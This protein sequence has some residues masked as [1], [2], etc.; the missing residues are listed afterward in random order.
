MK[1]RDSYSSILPLAVLFVACMMLVARPA[2]AQTPLPPGVTIEASVSSQRVMLGDTIDYTITIVGN[3]PHDEIQAPGFSRVDGIS[4]VSGPAQSTNMAV[5]NGV[6]SVT[7]SWTFV[8]RTSKV[9]TITIPPA[10]VRMRNSWHETDPIDVVVEDGDGIGISARTNSPQI[11]QELRGNY[12]ALADVPS[13]VFEGQAVPVTVYIYR[14]ESIPSFHQWDVPRSAQGSDFII[15][16][17][18][19]GRQSLNWTKV[20]IGDRE[21]LR[22]PLYTTFVVPTRTGRLKL[23]PPLTRIFFPLQRRTSSPVDDF[24][25]MNPRSNMIAAEC[26]I[27]PIE[28]E[29]SRL[30]E[31]KPESHAQV[32]GRAFVRASVDREELPHR[33]LLTLTLEVSGNAF[34]DTISRP[35]LPNIPHFTVVNATSEGSSWVENNNL[36]SQ[37]KFQYVL[38]AMNPGESRVP[39][40]QLEMINPVSGEVEVTRTEEIDLRIRQSSSGAILVGGAENG[41]SGRNDVLHSRATG[42]VIGRD[43]AYIDTSPLTSAAL[44]PSAAF[45]LRPWFWGAQMLLFLG[46]LGYGLYQVHQRRGSVESE[47]MR[48]KRTRRE[49][50][51]ALNDSRE[52]LGVESRDEFYATLSG[53]IRSFV[54]SRLGRSAQGLTVDDAVEGVG[55]TGVGEAVVKELRELLNHCDGIRYSPAED[56]R[57][58]RESALNRAEKLL[59]SLDGGD[60]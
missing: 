55:E 20:E 10:R 33:E 15:P 48:L 37:R 30:P 43:V 52:K 24:L 32:V 41:P 58:A 16:G 51:K 5:I 50:E 8:V 26:L 2:A 18:T 60:Q 17:Q 44:A 49:M 6:S 47:S 34:L 9:G 19:D 14:D 12:F 22:A 23:E 35:E 11:N 36:L 39:P 56:T 53:G 45:Y 3:V 1:F 13:K 4:L 40:I 46:F 28:I 31:K 59:V 7:R 25:R 57:E 29:V 54:A 21:F 38:Q 42:R 27:A